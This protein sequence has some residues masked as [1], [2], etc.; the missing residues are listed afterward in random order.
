MRRAFLPRR[1]YI[2]WRAFQLRPSRRRF[3]LASHFCRS[4]PSSPSSP[5][6]ATRPSKRAQTVIL[7]LFYLKFYNPYGPNV[8]V[9]LPHRALYFADVRDVLD[10]HYCASTGWVKNRLLNRILMIYHCLFPL[11][12]LIYQNKLLSIIEFLFPQFNI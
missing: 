8:S 12:P 1:V 3:P 10:M 6:I 9:D 5:F 4:S 11:F 7:K 2:V